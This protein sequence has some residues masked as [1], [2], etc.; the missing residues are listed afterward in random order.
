[1][2]DLPLSK[3]SDDYKRLSWKPILMPRH[4]LKHSYRLTIWA[5]LLFLCNTVY[6]PERNT[7]CK[8]QLKEM[9]NIVANHLCISISMQIQYLIPNISLVQVYYK[10][11][12]SFLS[13]S[14]LCFLHTWEFNKSLKQS[15]TRLTFNSCYSKWLKAL[16]IIFFFINKNSIKVKCSRLI[17][18]ELHF[19]HFSADTWQHFM[20]KKNSQYFS[21]T[22]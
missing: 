7:I 8:H 3:L 14:S 6:W 12:F 17:L 10:S 18:H 19:C 9:L 4:T 11:C 1:M 20:A 15:K 16:T 21:H 2:S 5:A 22:F 13:S